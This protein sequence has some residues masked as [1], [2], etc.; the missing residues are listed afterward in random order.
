MKKEL[1]IAFRSLDYSDTI[2]IDKVVLELTDEDIENIKKASMFVGD[3]TGMWSVNVKLKGSFS[4]I[5]EE[6]NTVDSWRTDVQYLRVY[7]RTSI[8]FYAQCK[9]DAGDTLESEAFSI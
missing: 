6:G 3:N 1:E 7:A 9:W 8:Y 2:E 5:D 4:F